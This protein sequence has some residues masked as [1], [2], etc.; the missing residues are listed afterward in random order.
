MTWDDFDRW[1]PVSLRGAA[2][3]LTA[4]GLLSEP[5]ASV[6]VA[7][8]LAEQLPDGIATP[9]HRLWTVRSSGA[10]GSTVGH[11]WMRIGPSADVVE[12]FVLDIEVLPELRGRG[13]GRSAMLAAEQAARDAGASVV[14]LNVFAHNA[15]GVRLYESLG[16]VVVGATLL[17]RLDGRPP[18]APPGPAPQRP[19]TLRPVDT[20]QYAGSGPRL[21]RAVDGTEA[22]AEVWLRLVRRSDGRHAIVQE[23]RLHHPDRLPAV[24]VAVEQLCRGLD[25]TSLTVS[26]PESLP[27]PP[28]AA[29]VLVERCGFRVAAQTMAKVIRP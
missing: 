4:S 16:Y 24:V 20:E 2:A 27:A 26:V 23:L 5:E 18:T 14:R 21:W 17:R 11:L 3:Q 19:V 13:W 12:A 10:G 7:E 1:T 15:A 29:Q 22:V 9:L 28:T 6:R 25:V 8:Q